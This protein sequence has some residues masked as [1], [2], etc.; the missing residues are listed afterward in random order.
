MSASAGFTIVTF[1]G[2]PLGLPCSTPVATWYQGKRGFLPPV[3]ILR[4]PPF[5]TPERG[6]QV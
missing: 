5:S 6:A 2:P 1:G 3:A 4:E